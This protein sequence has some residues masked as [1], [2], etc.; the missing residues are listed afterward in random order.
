MK[1]LVYSP[2]IVLLLFVVSCQSDKKSDSY[3]EQMNKKATVE[4]LLQQI[5]LSI[6]KVAKK[7][8]KKN[9]IEQDNDLLVYKYEL[10]ESDFYELTYAF[11]EL[12]CFEVGLDFQV[13]NKEQF[14]IL[15]EAYTKQFNELKDFKLEDDANGL[16]RWLKKDESI[17]IELDY[18][19]QEDGVLA[20]TIFA[21]E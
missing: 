4:E 21:N 1:K 17:T 14:G 6:D 19:L 9:L 3:Y 18:A 12:G 2:I 5:N 16:A 13:N 7:E 8:K 20:L 11:D 10:S 15:K